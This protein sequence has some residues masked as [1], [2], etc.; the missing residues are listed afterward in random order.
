MAKLR[1]VA[2][3]FAI[4]LAGALAVRGSLALVDLGAARRD[5]IVVGSKAFT[6]SIILAEITC[7]WLEENG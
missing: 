5:R 7:E 2:V 3:L 1:A 4:V 6:E